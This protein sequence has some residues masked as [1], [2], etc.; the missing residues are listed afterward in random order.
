MPNP[1]VN[2]K[3]LVK[4][5]L[6]SLSALREN[7]DMTGYVQQGSVDTF[8]NALDGLQQAGKDVSTWKRISSS[9]V[10]QG[11][12]QNEFRAKVDEVLMSFTIKKKKVAIGFRS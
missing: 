3:D 12:D 7:L 9:E 4:R 6:V 5:A 1:A 10:Y 2:T 8:N 11:V